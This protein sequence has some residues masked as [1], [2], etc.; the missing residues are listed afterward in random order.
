MAASAVMILHGFQAGSPVVTD[1]VAA[2]LL[3]KR[4]CQDLHDHN[5]NRRPAVRSMGQPTR[6]EGQA[7]RRDH[8]RV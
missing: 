5:L 7:G 2:R 8:F 1:P 4:S 3:P 6:V